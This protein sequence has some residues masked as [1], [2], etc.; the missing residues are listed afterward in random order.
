MR[1]GGREGDNNR[2]IDRECVCMGEGEIR[3]VRE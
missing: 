3:E 1:G 2:D